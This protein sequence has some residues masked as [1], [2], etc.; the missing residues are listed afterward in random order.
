MMQ[1]PVGDPFAD[2]DLAIQ[3]LAHGHQHLLGRLVFHDVAVGACAQR[4]FRVDRFVMHGEDQHR[5]ARISQ[6]NVL[7]QFEAVGSVQ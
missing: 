1:D 7:E 6:A 3:D 2:V 5:Q 4:A